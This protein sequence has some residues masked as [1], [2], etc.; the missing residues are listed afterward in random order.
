M[1]RF[2]KNY[3]GCLHVVI[4]I[5]VGHTADLGFDIYTTHYFGVCIHVVHVYYS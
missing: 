1:E 4:Y 5:C 3:G 2:D